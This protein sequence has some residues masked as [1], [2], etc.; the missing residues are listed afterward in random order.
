MPGTTRRKQ[1][2]DERVAVD[3]RGVGLLGGHRPGG[4]QP[5][6]DLGMPGSP[7]EAQRADPARVRSRSS[8]SSA[9]RAVVQG[10]VDGRGRSAGPAAD[11]RSPRAPAAGGSAA[12]DAEQ[13]LVAVAGGAGGSAGV[14]CGAYQQ[15]AGRARPLSGTAAVR[16]P[17]PARSR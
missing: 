9:S 3:D 12:R 2:Q 1:L 6:R 10:V 8:S 17:P 16:W 15:V 13:E 5:G 14:D 4:A 7:V 11:G